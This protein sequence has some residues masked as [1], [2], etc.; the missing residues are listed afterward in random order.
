V[1]E[2]AA[3]GAGA[4]R[5]DL[6]AARL[7][8]ALLEAADYGLM[9]GLLRTSHLRSPFIEPFTEP[10]I[11]DAISVCPPLSQILLRVLTLGETLPRDEA[12]AVLG[13]DVVGELLTAGV[14]EPVEQDVRSRFIVTAYLGRYL[15]ASPPLWLRP[16][17]PAEPIAY[18]GPESYWLGRFVVNAAERGR[19]LDLCAG[20]GLLSLLA[21]GEATI[22][23]E[24]DPAAAEVAAFNVALNGL[25][26]AVELRVGDLYGPVAGERFDLIVANPPFLPAPSG[27]TLP[28]C[29]DGGSH[30]EDVLRRIVLGVEEHLSPG[31][32]ALVYG[33][34]FG[35]EDEPVF[36][37]WL[38]ERV[39][40]SG[41]RCV[42]YLGAE[43][44][45]EAAGITLRQLWQAAGASEEL[46]YE[47]WGRLF[48]ELEAPM[49]YSF[50]VKLG[51]GSGTVSVRRLIAI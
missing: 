3:S 29:G 1:T 15:L 26:E 14:L 32:Q 18:I 43:Q 7:L 13:A 33:E 24:L 47:A 51:R 5:P 38:R 45:A 22:G 8:R 27:V 20:A 34:G 44:S 28:I 17:D 21:G 49:H 11:L 23:V 2:V 25:E 35:D 48:D 16:Y 31:G 42:I 46:A 12:E 50:V 30:G 37:S 4:V 19:V 39:A 10:R 40:G 36:A 41:L 6:G 9:Q